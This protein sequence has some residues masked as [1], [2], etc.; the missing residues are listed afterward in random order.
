MRLES[1]PYDQLVANGVNPSFA[2][3]LSDPDS[4]HPDL[5]IYVGKTNWDYYI[6]D[7]VTNIVPLWDSNADSYVRWTRDGNTEYVCAVP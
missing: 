4:Y 7:G 3:I 2:R 6:P 5:S 1:L